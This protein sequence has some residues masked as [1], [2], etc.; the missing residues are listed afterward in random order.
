M[1]PKESKEIRVRIA[2]SPT[3]FFHFGTART[4]LFNYLFAKKHNGKF[5]VRIEDTD[6]ER[7]KPEYEKDILD[8]LRWLGL[9]SDEDPIVGGSHGPY[10]QSERLDMYE[11][12]LKQLLS[13]NKAYYCFCAS[14]DLEMERKVMMESGIAPKYSGKCRSISHKEAEGKIEKGE[15]SIIRF[16]MPEEK[17]RFNDLIKGKIEM[18][19]SL[20]GDQ[21]IAKNLREPLYNFAVV[22]DDEEM[23][24]SDVIR[25]EDHLPNTPKQI[26]IQK[27]LGF[28]EV[29]YAHLPL[30]LNPDRSKMSKRFL[31]VS[32]KDYK[33]KGYLPSA[34]VNFM[35]LIGWHPEAKS[36]ESEK[37][38]FT[39]KELISEFS[40]ERVQKG[41][42]I[43]SEEKLD[44]IN[45]QFIKNMEDVHLLEELKL[46]G[47][48]EESSLSKE[49]V[50]KIIKSTKERMKNLSEF[51][52][53]AHFF[54]KLPQYDKNLLIWKKSNL[55]GAVIALNESVAI[56]ESISPENFKKEV[57]E[58]ELNQFGEKIGKGD[59]YWPVRV[60]LSG[61]EFS[62]PP[63]EIMDI[64]GKDES[65]K[66]VKSAIE[67]LEK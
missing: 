8:G 20:F 33:D 54:F 27:A 12:Y 59:L 52:N 9:N 39:I 46:R 41:G 2:P 32:V 11:K 66:R 63:Q 65:I 56:L 51:K 30:I 60:A 44:W 48:V 64:L 34:M 18:D 35:A 14:E 62:P 3:G 24:I 22:V 17:I 40:L 45:S 23:K 6:R 15:A 57:I 29:A 31:D 47:D 43:F 16:K 13:E 61:R 49:S 21:V 37:E 55:A 58:K 26:P 1:P 36:G 19:L 50:L 5:I 42:G 10:R 53:L 28:K 4:A 7:S 25:G 38:I 67:N